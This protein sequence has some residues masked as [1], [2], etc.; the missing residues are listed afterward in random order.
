MSDAS[1]RPATR[2][3]ASGTWPDDAVVYAGAAAR[4]GHENWDLTGLRTSANTLPSSFV[5]KF[6]LGLPDGWSLLA[7]ELCMALVDVRT[8]RAAG[9]V[10]QR[11]VKAL[12]VRGRADEV[13]LLAAFATETGRSM[14]GAW[15]PH[16]ADALL[17]WYG[18]RTR[19]HRCLAK[20]VE[21]VRDLHRFA[22]LLTDGALAFDP[23][24]GMAQDRV[25]ARVL[26]PDAPSQPRGTLTP[27]LPLE[28]FIPLVAAARAYVEVF[29]PDIVALHHVL[30]TNLSQLQPGNAADVARWAAEPTSRVPVHT[31]G[32]AA[33]RG[34]A[35]QPIWAMLGR[36]VGISH[37][38]VRSQGGD[39]IRSLVDAGRVYP[40]LGPVTAMVERA[41][42]TVG[43]WR[44][45]FETSLDFN[46]ERAMLRAAAYI[47]V[48]SLT[49]M[50]DSEAQ[51]LRRGAIHEHFGT[52]ALRTR[53]HK[54]RQAQPEPVSWWVCD[55]VLAA[56]RVLEALS[57]H[58][59]H[60]VAT[61]VGGPRPGFGARW[62]MHRFVAHVNATVAVTGLAPIPDVGQLGPQVLRETAAYAMGRFTE[63]GDLVVGHL[64]GHARATTTAAYQ[65]H[66]PGDAWNL[67]VHEG[68]IDGTLALLETMG[69]MV[70]GGEP[71][72][73]ARA[74]EL[75]AVALDVRATVVADPARARRLAELHRG[76]WHHGTVVSCRF[77]AG[78]AVCHRLARQ[79]GVADPEPGPLVDLCAGV[80][81]T[82]AHY[83][84]LQL[85]ALRARRAEA[86]RGLAAASAGSPGAHQLGGDLAE[87]DAVIAELEGRN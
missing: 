11:P 66:R 26:G 64:F 10:R 28:A 16:D 39:I 59:D 29:A 4:F 46:H 51:D 70:D 80:G 78:P 55:L 43:A 6:G 79:M 52:P 75:R 81:C 63:L 34:E 13:R 41:D 74:Q 65:R 87:L 20:M 15:A 5:V 86:A 22:P 17:I 56:Y 47:L 85:P 8:A 58:P 12:T 48:V 54:M 45:P 42:G 31:E 40:G 7:R 23:W 38:S 18:R 67:R 9:I 69:K 32:S 50:R 24:P 44:G 33:A 1:L 27:L 57:D 77:D 53:R 84:T 14:P 82:N 36:L 3:G 2:S 25:L 60:V 73:G 19:N 61:V 30:R 72:L 68:G 21:L 83:S 62:G 76:T 49:G 35:G 71:I 37:H